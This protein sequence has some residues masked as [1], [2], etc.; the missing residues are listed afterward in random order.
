MPDYQKGKIYKIVSGDLVYIGSTCEPTLARRLAFHVSAHK[1]FKQGNYR[2]TTS[3]ELIEKGQY[4][5]SLIESYPCQSKD[6]LHARERFWIETTNCVNKSIPGRTRAEYSK[7]YQKKNKDTLS[8]YNKEY[9]NANED[10]LKTQQK[11]WRIANADNIKV[12]ANQWRID[13][14]DKIKE[15]QKKYRDKLKLIK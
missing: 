5:I 2:H 12:K 9:R 15:Y 10:T 6:E 14:A 1:Q 4:D 3:I 7:I 13:N 8:E 11:E